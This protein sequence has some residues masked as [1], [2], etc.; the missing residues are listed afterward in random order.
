MRLSADPAVDVEGL[1][2][3][4]A[5]IGAEPLVLEIPGFGRRPFLIVPTSC[6]RSADGVCLTEAALRRHRRPCGGKY[7]EVAGLPVDI[8]NAPVIPEALQFEDNFLGLAIVGEGDCTG[9][10]ER[11]DSL[12][13]DCEAG[14]VPL[15]VPHER[16]A[17]ECRRFAVF[18]LERSILDDERGEAYGEVVINS[19][20]TSFVSE[21]MIDSIKAPALSID[22]PEQ[23]TEPWYRPEILI[24]F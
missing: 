11:T 15:T 5:H 8:R 24:P 20:Q 14:N 7:C 1:A 13:F 9:R 18:G 2:R 12:D 17:V 19:I 16:V 6:V 4:L 23:V 22:A 3:R 10:L 21:H